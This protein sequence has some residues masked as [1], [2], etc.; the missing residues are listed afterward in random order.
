M[1]INEIYQPSNFIDILLMHIQKNPIMLEYMED[2]VSKNAVLHH[3]SN[4]VDTDF[5]V[6]TEDHKSPQSGSHNYFGTYLDDY[7]SQKFGIAFRKDS[8]YTTLNG[9]SS[10][11]APFIL[12]PTGK[13]KLSYSEEIF[14]WYMTWQKE[15]IDIVMHR[16]NTKHNEQLIAD[17]VFSVLRSNE[18]SMDDIAKELNSEFIK[19]KIP[20]S[21]A[22]KLTNDIMSE[23]LSSI[24]NY[25][26]TYKVASSISEIP[27]SLKSTNN[28]IMVSSSSY[29]LLN[30]KKILSKTG[31]SPLQLFSNVIN[32]YNEGERFE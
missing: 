20:E 18:N 15:I 22:G 14:D 5:I 21:D 32:R 16:V 23:I 17:I 9:A 4:A 30:K 6:V 11:G 25:L 2:C 7:F 1:K 12:L 19:K 13:Y 27:E 26:S 10:Y 24:K 29:L 3:N 31:K 28:E 8:I